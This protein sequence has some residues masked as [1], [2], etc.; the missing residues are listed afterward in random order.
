[1]G[2]PFWW[3]EAYGTDTGDQVEVVVGPWRSSLPN[4]H[5][6]KFKVRSEDGKEVLEF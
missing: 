2:H 4:I 6:V 3:M 1:M 5:L